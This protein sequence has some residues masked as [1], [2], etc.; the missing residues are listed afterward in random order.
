MR[1]N[2]RTK[3]YEYV[4]FST[5]YYYY[6]KVYSLRWALYANFRFIYCFIYKVSS[7]IIAL[8]VQFPY[9]LVLFKNYLVQ[10]VLII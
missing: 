6:W 9:Y 10:N 4:V 8:H 1:N 5:L 7:L 2:V 3:S